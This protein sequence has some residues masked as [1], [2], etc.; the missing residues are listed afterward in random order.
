MLCKARTSFTLAPEAPPVL[1]NPR[2]AESLR[3]TTVPTQDLL[4]ISPMKFNR[5][6]TCDAALVLYFNLGAFVHRV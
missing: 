3:T 4:N 6:G 2:I 1:S 5:L